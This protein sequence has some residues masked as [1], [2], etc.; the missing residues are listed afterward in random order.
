[1]SLDPSWRQG[2][3]WAW[4]AVAA[5]IIVAAGWSTGT[6]FVRAAA[7]PAQQPGD[8]PRNP[9]LKGDPSQDRGHASLKLKADTSVPGKLTLTGRV[10]IQTAWSQLE[11]LPEAIVH[12]VYAGV[13]D[14]EGNAIIHEKIGEF[15]DRA[16]VGNLTKEYKVSY[17]MQPGTYI[18]KVGV[19]FP[20]QF[21]DK[22]EPHG[23]LMLCAEGR[24]V[25][26]V[27]R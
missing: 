3:K 20:P 9:R 4:K 19:C 13:S 12:D 15:T 25:N 23:R 27:G 14:L 1:M 11:G 24:R 10:V 22:T 8:F 26:V 7:R 18:A 16:G 2:R 21:Q 17:D 6:L 5:V